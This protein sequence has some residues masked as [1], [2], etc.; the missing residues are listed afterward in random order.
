MCQ[1]SLPQVLHYMHICILLAHSVIFVIE[2]S[3]LLCIAALIPDHS[4][5][6]E[7]QINRPWLTYRLARTDCP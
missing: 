7:T 1:F 6:S 2:L 3:H 5:D 4:D